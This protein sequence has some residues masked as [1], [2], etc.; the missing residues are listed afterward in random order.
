MCVYLCCCHIWRVT[1]KSRC[2]IF[3]NGLLRF[4]F[5]FFLFM[6]LFGWL[7]NYSLFFIFVL[8]LFSISP[9]VCTN[10]WVYYVPLKVNKGNHALFSWSFDL[11]IHFI[12][13]NPIAQCTMY[14]VQCVKMCKIRTMINITKENWIIIALFWIVNEETVLRLFVFV[15]VYSSIFHNILRWEKFAEIACTLQETC[16]NQ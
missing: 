2:I 15:F 1:T 4:I 6:Y 3:F 11:F 13:S 16:E 8:L 5:F 12:L 10:L 14:I 9:F 7:F